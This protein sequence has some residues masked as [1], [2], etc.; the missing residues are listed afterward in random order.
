MEMTELTKQVQRILELEFPGS[1]AILDPA[2]PLEKVGGLLIWN[3]F[4]Q[5]EQIDRQ[6]KL[7]AKLRE[8]LSRD[9]LLQITAIL[10][11]T[12]AEN[13]IPEDNC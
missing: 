6:R 3:G 5:M 11:L 8:K 1:T 10:T 4:D 12:P 13:A 9:D 2:S 7:M